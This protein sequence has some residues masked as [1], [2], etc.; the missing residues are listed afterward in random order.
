MDTA[1]KSPFQ[2]G[3]FTRIQDGISQTRRMPRLGKIRLG[4]KLMSP[5]TG[6]EYPVETKHFVCTPEV[7][8]VYGPEPT[9][10]DVMFPINNPLIVFPQQLEWYGSGKGLKCH[11]DKVN[12]SRR[13]E[14]GSWADRTCPCEHLK[15]DDNPQ[16]ECDE[17]GHLLV[18]IPSVSMGGVYQID[19]GSYHSIVDVNSGIDMVMAT[20]GRIAMVPLKLRRVPRDT[21][22]DQHKRTHYTLFL[23]LDAN[24]GEVSKL[25]EN[26]KLV[27]DRAKTIQLEAP[28]LEA[29]AA[30][31]VDG[32]ATEQDENQHIE[33]A[34]EVGQL[35][36]VRT[37]PADPY[38][39][40]GPA[41]AASDKGPGKNFDLIAQ[42][43]DDMKAAK[44]VK[45]LSEIG[46]KFEDDQH[47]TTQEKAGLRMTMKDRMGEVSKVPK[48]K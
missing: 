13:Q 19:T 17:R 21:H 41:A 31:P 36:D 34:Q 30:D 22:G 15:S 6:K 3:K 39:K 4:M 8:A 2:T 9:E 44:H 23:G 26:S 5:R 45:E 43:R 48:R 28:K 1:E 7:Q 37:L 10:L 46:N 12:A 11:G 27:L 29:P 38:P 16:G 40:P 25:I 32:L 47:L 33:E 14:D 35:G 20:V 24:V 18:M 42:Y